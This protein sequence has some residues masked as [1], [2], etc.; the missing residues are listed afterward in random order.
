MKLD[1]TIEYYTQWGEELRIT[2]SIPLLGNFNEKKAIPL[3][4]GDGKIWKLEVETDSI[5]DKILSYKYILF[6]DGK[7]CRREPSNIA[8][9]IDLIKHKAIKLID[10]WYDEPTALIEAYPIYNQ[11]W[12]NSI[13]NLQGSSSK[14]LQRGK[15]L[16]LKAHFAQ[17]QAN[18]QLAIIGNQKE[19]GYWSCDQSHKLELENGI[20]AITELLI[21]KIKFPLEYKYIVIDKETQEIKYWENGPNR[22]LEGYANLH[23]ISVMIDDGYLNFPNRKR[24][25]GSGVAI[26]IFSLRSKNSYGIGEFTDLKLLVDWASQVGMKMIQILPINDTTSSYGWGDSYPYRC[27]SVFALNPIYI[28]LIKLG[29]LNTSEADRYKKEQIELNQLTSIDFPTVQNRKLNYLEYLYKLNFIEVINNSTYIEFYNT[30]KEW[31]LPY[32]AYLY[33][34]KLYGTDDINN[35]G[36]DAVFSVKRVKDL[37]K[38]DGILEQLQFHFYVQYSLHQQLK[39]ATDYAIS[40]HVAIKGDLPIG[41]SKKSV[42]AWQYPKLFNMSN[43]AGAPPDAFAQLG[44]NWGF[45]TYNW[46]EMAKD[47]YLWWQQRLQQMERYYKAYRIDHILGFF[48]IWSIPLTAIDGTLGQ[49]DPALP[50]SIDEMKSWGFYFDEK[51]IR[52]NLDKEYIEVYFANEELTILKEIFFIDNGD[53]T[54][55]I[56]EEYNTQVRLKESRMISGPNFERKVLNLYSN[57]LF[58]PDYKNKDLYHP[59][60]DGVKTEQFER[61]SEEQKRAY[62]CI[63]NDFFYNRHNSYWKNKAYQKLPALIR[64]SNMLV[65]GEDLGMIPNSVPE[66]MNNLSILS[67]EVRRMPKESNKCIGNPQDY[68]YFSVSTFSTHDMPT[69]RGWWKNNPELRGKLLNQIGY[70]HD[71]DTPPDDISTEDAKAVIDSELKGNS[72][73]CIEAIQDWLSL[74]KNYKQLNTEEEQINIPSDIHHK[75]SYRLPCKVEDLINDDELNNIIAKLIRETNR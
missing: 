29:I 47:G 17:L 39:E 51:Q 8:H 41:I 2:G 68:P 13:D 67:L 24:W 33:F 10:R 12:S 48:R 75:W 53:D 52:P 59:R 21:N 72:V 32:S 42:D 28:D 25:K 46:N 57:I 62:L 50:L 66:V 64:A 30:N 40:K 74:S 14:S 69:L 45:P 73:L 36:S 20:T 65:C 44:Q 7:I 23:D 70:N 5:H 19:L 63:Y 4:S 56:K 31:L 22:V 11:V 58:I 71:N 43:Q 61:L 55:R 49:F 15:F 38:D 26:P 1:L 37:M 60:I 16:I 9:T 6:K 54:Y 35:W 27:I 3:S 18:E 34:R